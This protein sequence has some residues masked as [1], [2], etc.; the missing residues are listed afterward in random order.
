[1]VRYLADRIAVMY[2]GRIQEIGPTDAIFN[3]PNHPYTEALLSAIPSVDGEERARIRLGGEI[4]SPANPPSG[5]VFHP[6]CPRA[7]EGVCSESEP[8]LRDV[9][10]GHQM[11][12]H[13][14]AEQLVE[15]QRRG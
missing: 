10:P 8:P 11:R 9:A 14:P 5:C 4:P 6:R 15:L 12:C 1:V 2:L 13:I 7:I 3:G